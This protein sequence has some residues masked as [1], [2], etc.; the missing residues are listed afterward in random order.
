MGFVPEPSNL[1]E[2]FQ[3]TFYEFDSDWTIDDGLN[4]RLREDL[5]KTDIF[6]KAQIELR[7]IADEN[8]KNE[9]LR[10]KI[11]FARDLGN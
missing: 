5:I 10:L 9:L 1:T 4:E 8:I 3:K 6:A 11:A 2:W 7:E